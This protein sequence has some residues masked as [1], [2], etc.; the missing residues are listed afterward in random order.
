[1]FKLPK[2]F[3]F[4]KSSF[5][6]KKHFPSHSSLLLPDA[7][8]SLHAAPRRLWPLKRRNLQQKS[9]QNT[10][11]WKLTTRN[12]AK[13]GADAEKCFV[14]LCIQLAPNPCRVD[15]H[16]ELVMGARNCWAWEA[17]LVPMCLPQASCLG[18]HERVWLPCGSA[19]LFSLRER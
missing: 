12:A 2:P 16:Y 14:Y 1:M 8:S 18:L 7:P 19:S 4:I 11:G 10:C 3:I 15:L 13:P 5:H 17:T 6:N 9:F